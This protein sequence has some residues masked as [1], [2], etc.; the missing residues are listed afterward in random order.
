MRARYGVSVVSLKSDLSS[1]A[2]VIIWE[3]GP[4][5][6]G[7]QLHTYKRANKTQQ[8]ITPSL[9]Y[10]AFQKYNKKIKHHSKVHSKE[11]TLFFI[12][13]IFQIIR[14]HDLFTDK[15]HSMELGLD[16]KLRS[17]S[18]NWS[19]NLRSWSWSWSWSWYSGYWPE[20]ELKLELTP[21]LLTIN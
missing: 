2:V 16:F 3:I 9:E 12:C 7:T 5:Y 8:A 18:W 13:N 4:Y 21:T 11:Y 6:N 19:W 10:F 15:L 17:W 20:L 14:M 1:T